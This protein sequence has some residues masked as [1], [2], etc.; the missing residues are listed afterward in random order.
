[1]I[2]HGFSV[3]LTI[4]NLIACIIGVIIGTLTGV[5]P[6]LGVTGAIA[7][8]L[9]LSYGMDATSALIMFAGIYY[10]AMY[11]G[12][13]T[14]ILVN[15]PGE[16]ASVITA[17]DGHAMAKKG[18]AG[19]ALAIAAIGSFVAGTLG[20]IGLTLFAPPLAKAALAFGP[21]EFFAIAI[22]GLIILSNLTG[23]SVLKSILMVF[24][25]IMLGTIGTDTI[26]GVNRFTFNIDELQRGIDFAVLAMGIF[27]IPEVISAITE[28][29]QDA[30]IQK[31]RFR[32]LY[33][34]KE[35]I[36]R[37]LAPMFRGG[38]VGFLCGLI[39]GPSATISTFLSYALEKRW[40]KHPE[41]FGKGA[42]EGV[43]GPESANNAATSATMIPLLSLGL[44]FAPPSAL[45]LTGFIIHGITPGP[46]LITQYPSIFWGLIASMYIGNIL[47]LII[48][49]PLVGVFAS[50]LKTPIQILMPV[51]T[52]IT[53]TGAYAVN[54][55]LFDLWLLILFG[56]TGYFMKK[57][58]YEPAPLAIGLV[59]GP[60]LERGLTQG[61]IMGDGNLLY[62]FIRPISGTILVITL[63]ILSFIVVRWLGITLK[64]RTAE[65]K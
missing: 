6:G 51:I 50:L 41:E 57:G 7:L 35:E 47:L 26:A 49:L 58:G 4:Q 54:N 65:V 25:G 60:T 8:L 38:V 2:A 37:S 59:L 19:A 15:L 53:L 22:L 56:V 27:G 9:P 63:L 18:R 13:T 33:P 40:S 17:I 21:P 43:A 44:P 42:V 12:S 46:T 31:V 3:S 5:L 23:T 64:K 10:G 48:N 14:S 20:L 55:S 1:M 34:N 52:I 28:P 29:S 32:E 36:K 16:A 61:L 45:L 24:V 39:P 11:G 30:I 62:F